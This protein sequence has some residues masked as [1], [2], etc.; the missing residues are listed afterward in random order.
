MKESYKTAAVCILPVNI[1]NNSL[2]HK[3]RYFCE[4]VYFAD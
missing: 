1:N 3:I 4:V 2:L